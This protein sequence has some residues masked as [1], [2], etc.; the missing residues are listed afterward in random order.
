MSRA[1]VFRRGCVLALLVLVLGGAFDVFGASAPAAG[2]IRTTWAYKRRYAVLED[3]AARF[4]MKTAK[5]SAQITLSGNGS[6]LQL[7]PQKRHAFFNGVR[8]ALAY[9]PFRSSNGLCYLSYLDYLKTVGPLIGGKRGYNHAIRTIVID[10]GHGGKDRGAA[11]KLYTEKAITL[12]LANRLA[13]VLRSYGYTVY[14]TRSDDRYIG[15]DERSAYA[16]RRKADLFLSLHVNAAADRSV[17]G[18]ETFCMTPAGAASTNSSTADSR[19][20]PGNRQDPNNLL[21]AYQ[22]QKAL[23]ERTGAEDRGV[24]RARFAVLRQ[25]NCPGVLIELG[26]ISNA[27]EERNLGSAVYQDKLARAIAEGVVTYRRS[28]LK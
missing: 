7:F 2:K 3:I 9:S 4:G 24:K 27:V 17:A 21:L 23:T 12:S 16:T 10:P 5:S 19:V 8:L 25:L 22:L 26:F 11:G 6:R 13:R 15:L 14:L 1:A 28:L 18:I 20:Y